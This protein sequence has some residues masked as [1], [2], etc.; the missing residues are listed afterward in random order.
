ACS[1][2]APTDGP[3]GSTIPTTASSIPATSSSRAT[4]PSGSRAA[5]SSASAAA[6]TSRGCGER[7]ALPPF[8]PAH[9]GGRPSSRAMLGTQNNRPK[10]LA[11]RPGFPLSRERT[12]RVPSRSV[13][14]DLPLRLH[15]DRTRARQ[16]GAITIHRVGHGGADQRPV[17]GI[18][19]LQLLVAVDDRA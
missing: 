12:D 19:E 5:D 16:R 17:L 1:Q 8:V 18:V 7:L 6:R 11:S 4:A 14:N 10:S 2:A 15:G 9:K 13:E 3:A